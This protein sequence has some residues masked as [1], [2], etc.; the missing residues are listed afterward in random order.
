MGKGQFGPAVIGEA[1]FKK[2]QE[3]VA[4]GVDYF[5]PAV[6]GPS[7]PQKFRE[8]A[9][10]SPTARPAALV[11]PTPPKERPQLSLEKLEE[12]LLDNPF[13][14]DGLIEAEFGRAEGPRKGAVRLLEK[15]EL[16][17]TE[18]TQRPEVLARLRAVLAPPAPVTA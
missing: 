16:A 17:K 18:N 13:M 7:E 6:V 5:G 2:E 14:L 10:H 9:G 11:P 15:V 1:A 8:G 12:A 4:R 3:D